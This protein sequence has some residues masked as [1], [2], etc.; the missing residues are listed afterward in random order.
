MNM[1]VG[2]G[3]LV[4][5]QRHIMSTLEGYHKNVGDIMI[6]M[7]DILPTGET[8]RQKTLILYIEKYDALSIH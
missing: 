2:R 4:Y 1:F 5:D 8:H 7:R 3:C 6:H